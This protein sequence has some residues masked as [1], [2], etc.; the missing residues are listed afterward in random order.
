MNQSALVVFRLR[1]IDC[2]IEVGNIVPIQVGR[3]EVRK[4][5]GGIVGTSEGW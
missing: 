3:S 1:Y 4:R 5:R 2:A